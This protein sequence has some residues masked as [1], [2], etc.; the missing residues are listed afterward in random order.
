MAHSRFRVRSLC[1]ST[2]LLAVIPPGMET[3]PPSALKTNSTLCS[4]Y[5]GGAD[6]T[7]LHDCTYLAVLAMY[8]RQTIK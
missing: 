3:Y 8:S 2:I 1:A 5:R 7:V 4:F 6:K